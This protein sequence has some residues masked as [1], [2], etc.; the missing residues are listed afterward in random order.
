MIKNNIYSLL[1]RF[2]LAALLIVAVSPS[3]K[4]IDRQQLD[5]ALAKITVISSTNH[6]ATGFA[7][8][9]KD[10]VVTSLHA[11]RKDASYIVERPGKQGEWKAVPIANLPDHDLVLLELRDVRD[12]KKTLPDS[13]LPD[14]K[15]FTSFAPV[16]QF[17]SDVYA[18]GYYGST[19]Q[20]RIII[21]KVE[22]HSPLEGKIPTEHA[23]KLRKSNIPN[24]SLPVIH[25]MGTTLMPGYSGAPIANEKGELVAIGNGGLE[26][27]AIDI[28]WGIH[29][30]HLTSLEKAVGTKLPTTLASI[31]E[32][33]SAP[34]STD[35][36]VPIIKSGAYEFVFKK[37][38]SLEEL[39]SSADAPHDLAIQLSTL[40]SN[41]DMS[42]FRYDIY[43]DLNYGLIIAT[44]AGSE[45][46]N[47]EEGWLQAAA[48][49]FVIVYESARDNEF[50]TQVPGSND[51]LAT[52]IDAYS[53]GNSAFELDEETLSCRRSTDGGVLATIGF[54]NTEGKTYEYDKIAIKGRQFLTAGFTVDLAGPAFQTLEQNSCLEDDIAINCAAAGPCAGLCDALHALSSA[55]LTSFSSFELAEGNCKS[56]TQD[57]LLA[58][59]DP[60]RTVYRVITDDDYT[61]TVDKFAEA[62]ATLAEQ[63]LYMRDMEDFV[64]GTRWS[65]AGVLQP[66]PAQTFWRVWYKYDEF[67]AEVNGLAQGGYQLKDLEVTW[68]QGVWWYSGVFQ[69]DPHITAF[70]SYSTADELLASFNA[71]TNEGWSLIDIETPNNNESFFFMAVYQYNAGA[72]AY[73]IFPDWNQFINETNSLA[74]GGYHLT[75]IEVIQGVGEQ[76]YAGV[77]SVN[78]SPATIWTAP[79]NEFELQ[80]EQFRSENLFLDDLEV[81]VTANGRWGVGVFH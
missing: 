73:R 76:W 57:N 64:E 68:D 81:L 22:S 50:F 46:V 19:P 77:Y 18:L 15:P 51:P 28:S 41:V 62:A 16:P 13:A 58:T 32:Q 14:W 65:L 31:S 4:A 35:A 10:W 71:Y 21:P 70:E 47:V 66:L 37:T 59:S 44:P 43:Q 39:M 56:D 40:A 26:N 8:R 69:S 38:R 6:R 61:V 60:S 54:E 5:Q 2:T 17:G 36:E 78:A 48:G 49:D 11:M 1:L 74:A 25:L 29:A 52:L 67:L 3:A 33:Y 7:W 23:A 79:M 80:V 72:S 9:K 20:P 42:S 34:V 53:G 27:G 63:G 55:H 30:K 45:L 24:V 75:D 12:P